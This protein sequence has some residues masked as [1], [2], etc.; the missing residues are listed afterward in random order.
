MIFLIFLSLRNQ[1][2]N[3]KV[4]GEKEKKSHFDCLIVGAGQVGL[5]IAGCLKALGGVNFV[6]LEKNAEV[7]D[8]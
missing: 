8:N 2:Q 3:G 6:V 5:D 1:S 4:G 7:G